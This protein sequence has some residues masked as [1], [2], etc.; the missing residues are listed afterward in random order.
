RGNSGDGH[1][2]G[3]GVDARQ[4]IAT[5]WSEL[6]RHHHA[7]PMQDWN[8][9]RI[10]SQTRQR[11]SDLALWHAYV[12]GGMAVNIPRLR[13]INMHRD[14][15]RSY[16]WSLASRLHKIVQRRCWDGCDDFDRRN[17]WIRRRRSRGVDQNELQETS[18]S[19][20]RW[21]NGSA[22]SPNGSR[23]RDHFRRRRN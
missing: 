18:G 2:A 6:P 13:T 21:K 3:E 7:W 1:D 22:R 15:R 23:R 8:Y 9:A 19:I 5:D 12:R 14:R 10:H 4:E 17:R 20:Y 16:S 11:W